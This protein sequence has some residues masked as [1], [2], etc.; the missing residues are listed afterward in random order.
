MAPFFIILGVVAYLVLLQDQKALSGWLIAP[1][2]ILTVLFIFQHQI[3]LWW[4]RRNPPALDPEIQGLL[5]SSLPVLK[6]LTPEHKDLFDR[7]LSIYLQS[8]DFIDPGISNVPTD[9]HAAILA[10]AVLLSLKDPDQEWYENYQRIVL[11]KHPFLTPREDRVHTAEIDIED[12]TLIISNEQLIPGILQPRH[13]MHL[14]AY[15]YAQAYLDRFP[16]IKLDGEVDQSKM[17][18]HEKVLGIEP[19]SMAVRLLEKI[20]QADRWEELQLV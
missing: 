19:D 18:L 10:P 8:S 14:S 12:G 1:V 16:E 9:I 4:W 3:N 5:Y 13:Q 7:R 11:Y 15:L 2:L 20:I 6:S 17:T